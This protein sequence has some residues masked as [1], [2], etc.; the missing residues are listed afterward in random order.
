MS[1]KFCDQIAMPDTEDLFINFE[2]KFNQITYNKKAFINT[3]YQKKDLSKQNKSSDKLK[4]NQD[5]DQESMKLNSKPIK[6]YESK[7]A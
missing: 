2:Q 6:K 7:E 1:Q 3:L 4:N 5:K